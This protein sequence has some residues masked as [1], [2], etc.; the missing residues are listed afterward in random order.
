MFVKCWASNTGA[1][2]YTLSPSQYFM[3][4]YLHVCFLFGF[5]PFFS[6][7]IYIYI[8]IYIYSTYNIQYKTIEKKTIRKT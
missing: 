5:E 4:R 3:L 2:Q 6:D 7:D 8:Y 1:G